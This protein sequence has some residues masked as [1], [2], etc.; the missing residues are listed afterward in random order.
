MLRPGDPQLRTLRAAHSPSQQGHKLWNATWL[1]LSYLEK[2]P[3]PDGARIVEVGC[4]WGLAGIA[5][6]RRYAAA[7]TAV[8]VDEEVFPFL[9]LHARHNEVDVATLTA[10]FEEISPDLLSRQDMLIG[11]DICF[12][13]SM[14]SPLVDLVARALDAGVR[15]VVLSDPG[16]LAFR[17]LAS[18]C[19]RELGGEEISW[20]VPEPILAWP[21]DRPMMQGRLL[22]IDNVSR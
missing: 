18:H 14:V 11:A 20:Q 4:G 3:P 16:R 13:S 10:G 21:G 19:A 12:R 8:D 5:C 2:H 7:V 1:L 22:V 17:S 6:A 15:S 9:G